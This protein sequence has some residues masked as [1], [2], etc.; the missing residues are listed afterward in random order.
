MEDLVL[1]HVPIDFEVNGSC[2]HSE[3]LPRSKRSSRL[4]EGRILAH[5]GNEGLGL[6]WIL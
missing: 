3:S 5:Y 6:E 2:A 1:Y 4:L